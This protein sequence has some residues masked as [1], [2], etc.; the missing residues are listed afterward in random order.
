MNNI[1]Q[2]YES[3]VL[4]TV[5]SC[6]VG[7]N[8]YIK[9]TMKTLPNEVDVVLNKS[10]NPEAS[11]CKCPAGS[12]TNALC[13]HVA[14]LLFGVENMVRDKFILLHEDC[15]QNLPKFNLSNK[16]VKQKKTNLIFEPYPLKN[17]NKED[18][19]TRFRNLI[20]GFPNSN[21]LLKQL[22]EAASPDDTVWNDHQYCSETPT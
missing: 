1:I 9:G 13:K 21:M 18:Y 16:S 20:L 5:K 11:L 2:L 15:T 22:Y 7:D 14:V 4:L 6:I 17:M 19:N 10:G 12:G 3:R 8:T